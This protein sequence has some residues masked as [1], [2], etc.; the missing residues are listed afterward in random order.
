MEDVILD[1]L[2]PA[3][4]SLSFGFSSLLLVIEAGAPFQAR[5]AAAMPELLRVGQRV[6]LAVQCLPCT[7][8][9]QTQVLNIL[10]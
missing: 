10:D 5:L 9:Q 8:P 6:G 7:T 4:Y 3:L 2:G 1:A